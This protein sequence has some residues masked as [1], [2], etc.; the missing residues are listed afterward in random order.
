MDLRASDPG[1][2]QNTSRSAVTLV[3]NSARNGGTGEVRV[4][5]N[6]HRLRMVVFDLDG[7]LTPVDSLWRYLHDAFGTWGQAKVAAQKYRRGEIS[8]K[9]WAETDAHYW[10]GTPLTQ[11]KSVLEEIPYREGVREVFK[12]LKKREVKTVILSAGLSLLAEKAGKELGADLSIANELRT[13]DGRLTGEVIVKVAVNDKEGIIERL[14]S[15]LNVPL[16]DVALVGDRAFDL[17]N[18]QCLKIAYKPKDEVAR[19]EADFV[20]ED[21]DMMAILQYLI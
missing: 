9:T 12:E 13:D 11:V 18:E 15:Q 6:L 20:V 17:S 2:I 3:P 21:D 8:Y 4:D 16:R 19:R 5:H 1:D 10:A 7:T 14:A